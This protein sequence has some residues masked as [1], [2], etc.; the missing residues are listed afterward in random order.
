[1]K[2]VSNDTK[3]LLAIKFLKGIGEKTISSLS[4]MRDFSEMSIQDILTLSLNKKDNYSTADINEASDMA[5]QQIDIAEKNGHMIISFFDESYSLNLKNAGYCAPILFCN[6]NI[7]CLNE[8]NLTIIGTREPTKHG[9]IIAEKITSWFVKKGWNI[10]SGLAFGVDSIAHSACIEGNGKTISV[11][12][13]GLEKIYPAK[14]KDLAKRIVDKG[15]LLVSEYPY[16]SYV[17]R[18]NF[19]QRDT[20][21]AAISTA[22]ILI[23]TGIPGGS[24]HASRA[25]LQ[26][27]RPLIVAG[28]SKSD[29]INK[30]VKAIGNNTLINSDYEEIRKILKINSF[31]KDL[32]LPLVNKNHY[33]PIENKLRKITKTNHNPNNKLNGNMDLNF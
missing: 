25:S 14:N 8:D 13:H 2:T 11:L 31:N 12:A 29:I 3:K 16:N 32:I 21:Q 6:G 30:E 10:V 22:V 33:E 4:T 26:F 20:I 9:K 28:Q 23:Q 7:N 18:S 1:M 15:G 27:G 19:V 5:Q 24:L 17:G